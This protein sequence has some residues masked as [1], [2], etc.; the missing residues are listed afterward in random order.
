MYISKNACGQT[1]VYISK[2][3][4]VAIISPKKNSK[5]KPIIMLLHPLGCSQLHLPRARYPSARIS[6]GQGGHS[7]LIT[8]CIWMPR[9]AKAPRATNVMTKVQHRFMANR[10]RPYNWGSRKHQ[11]PRCIGWLSRGSSEVAEEPIGEGI[12]R[13]VQR[14]LSRA[15]LIIPWEDATAAEQGEYAR[16]RGPHCPCRGW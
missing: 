4:R 2:N 14:L 8:R 5:R 6:Q 7:L 13:T 3:T 1:P 11:W 15:V 9:H 16:Q 10:V 12:T